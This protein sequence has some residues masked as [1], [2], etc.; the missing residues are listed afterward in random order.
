MYQRIAVACRAILALA[1]AAERIAFLKLILCFCGVSFVIPH[2]RWL[3]LKNMK[4]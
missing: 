4:V 2:F 1:A 3:I